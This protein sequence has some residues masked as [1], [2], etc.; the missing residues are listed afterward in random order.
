MNPRKCF[1]VPS[2]L[3]SKLTLGSILVVGWG[4]VGE[5]LDEE[6]G[7]IGR[8][9]VDA[10]GELFFSSSSTPLP[11]LNAYPIADFQLSR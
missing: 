10:G 3:S 6:P 5:S 7:P 1:L 11:N 4:G 2:N 8:T 9:F